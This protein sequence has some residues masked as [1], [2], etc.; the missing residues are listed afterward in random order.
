MPP[1][2]QDGEGLIFE[3]SDTEHGQ[4]LYRVLVESSRDSIKILDLDGRLLTMNS[5]GQHLMEISDLR[6]WIG[7]PWIDLWAGEH[8]DKVRHALEEARNGM[9][10][11]FEAYRP[12][13]KGRPKWWDVIVSP[14]FGNDGHPHRLLAIARDI[15]DRKRAE[16][17][18]RY[19]A[20]A[21]FAV[22]ESLEYEETVTNVVNVLVPGLADWCAIDVRKDDG[23]LTLAAIA[24]SDVA[25]MDYA[26]DLRRRFP[27]R[28]DAPIGAYS[29]LRSGEPIVLSEISDEMLQ[30]TVLS[31]EHY[32]LIKK[33]GLHSYAA[34]P[35]KARGQTFG[36]MTVVSAESGRTFD[37]GDLPL[38]V[39]LGRIC[40]LAMDNARLYNASRSELRERRKVE[41]KL[42]DLNETLEA[43]VAEKTEDLRRVNESLTGEVRERRRAERRLEEANRQLKLRNREL[44]E[45]AYAASH[46]LQE[47]LRKIRS[48]ADL[49]RSDLEGQLPPMGREYLDRI[50]HAAVRMSQLIRDLLEYSRVQTRRRETEST[51]LNRILEEVLLDLE[52]PIKETNAEIQA[53]RLPV[54]EADASQMRQ[55]FQN[56]ISNALKFRRPEIAP[57]IRITADQN[58]GTNDGSWRIAFAD[59]GIGFEDEHANRIFTPFQ[60]LHSQA[61]YSGTGIGLAI[62]RRI[63]E[64]H[65]GTISAESNPNE[66]ATFIVTLPVRQHHAEPISEA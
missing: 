57:F 4:S 23:S 39:E 22:T 55:L 15:T 50:D 26:R 59:N 5:S 21:S 42:R 12:T 49:M 31:D 48:F 46:D 54:I 60:R 61:K 30:E 24:H 19:V 45:F 34:A 1:S 47:P 16:D 29:V 9:T 65:D 32:D 33:L 58:D 63:V 37:E 62:C 52:V 8:G 2:P 20:E 43:R 36:V 18:I 28:P 13:T 56:L 3:G 38:L 7:K 27:P 64:R 41:R 44:Q 40:G 17:A 11:R 66:G 51:D 10:G 14:I 6:K 35:L 25:K 53:D